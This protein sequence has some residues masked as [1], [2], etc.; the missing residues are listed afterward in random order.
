MGIRDILREAWRDFTSRFADFVTYYI[1]YSI[2]VA[3]LLT[4]LAIWLLNVFVSSTGR[5][6]I[7]DYDLARYALSPL[8]IIT[9]IVIGGILLGLALARDTGTML[10]G[11]GSI[12]G[13]RVTFRQAFAHMLWRLPSIILLTMQIVLLVLLIAIPFLIVIG[14]ILG[15]V[16]SNASINYYLDA[17]PPEWT[18]AITMVVLV[19]IPLILILAY[20]YVRFSFILATMLFQDKRG[21]ASLKASGQLVKGNFLKVTL[22]RLGWLII[23]FSITFAIQGIYWRIAQSIFE[24]STSSVLAIV[25][26]T[27]GILV[28]NFILLAFTNFFRTIL[29]ALF[30]LHLYHDVAS[31]RNVAMALPEGLD[32]ADSHWHI[33]RIVWP[34]VAIG[35]VIA[36]IIFAVGV[37]QTL[38][39]DTEVVN[40]AHRGASADAPENSLAATRLALAQNADIIEIDVQETKDGTIVVLHDKD[41]ERVTGVPQFIYEV[42]YDEIKDLDSGSWYG[43]EFADERIPTLDELLDLVGDQAIVNIELKY[44]GKDEALAE[45]VVEIVE[46]RGIEDQVVLMSLEYGGMEEVRQLNPDLEIGLLA[47]LSVGDLTELDVDFL[48]MS[49]SAVDRAFIEHA[50]EKGLDVHVWTVNEP[51]DMVQYINLGVD[52]IITDK[53]ELLNQ[54][55]AELESMSAPE[56]ALIQLSQL[57]GFSLP[58]ESVEQ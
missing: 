54:V 5:A 58:T 37:S 24:A 12:N 56:R 36:V 33:P 3:V 45:R 44:N 48:A 15:N 52:N 25:I 32:S 6:A 28:V 13:K 43:A 22:L 50:H 31:E 19:A 4:P 11:F 23:A 39:L 38:S 51:E 9:I 17:K 26:V 46:R 7:S 34:I 21:R 2:I 53:P 49:A 14:L 40:T 35:T 8:G 16:L 18:R 30:T 42:T 20:G 47:A 29:T 57:L 55:M 10:I 41:I 1:L 27:A